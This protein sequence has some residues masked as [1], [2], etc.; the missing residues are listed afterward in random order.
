VLLSYVVDA[1][2][3]ISHAVIYRSE[4]WWRGQATVVS[5]L[6]HTVLTRIC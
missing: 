1:A 6:G 4:H 3:N 5:P 2:I